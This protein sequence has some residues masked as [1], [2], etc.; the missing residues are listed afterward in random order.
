MCYDSESDS[1]SGEDTTDSD[2]DGDDEDDDDSIRCQPA[3]R[4]SSQYSNKTLKLICVQ[5]VGLVVMAISKV[6]QDSISGSKS[7]EVPSS[8]QNA[9]EARKRNLLQFKHVPY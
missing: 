9:Q 8:L 3:A 5:N 2:Y 6:E 7:V 1:S 4:I